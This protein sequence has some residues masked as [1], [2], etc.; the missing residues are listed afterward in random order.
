MDYEKITERIKQIRIVKGYKRINQYA[1]L[2][3]YDRIQYGRI[4][5]GKDKPSFVLF[6]RLA[7]SLNVSLDWLIFG[8]GLMFRD[9]N[10]FLESV[11]EIYLEKFKIILNLSA[12][13]REIV[14]KQIDLSLDLTR[15][16]LL[17][18]K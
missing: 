18:L 12:E 4:E 6:Y 15:S 9:N 16:E 17:K 8:E 13:K 5:K 11:P 7:E 3:E 2:I 1:A 10:R 14:L